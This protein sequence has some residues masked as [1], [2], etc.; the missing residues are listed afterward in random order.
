[1]AHPFDLTDFTMLSGHLATLHGR[2]AE[3]APTVQ[4]VVC[5][6]RDVGAA[7]D[8]VATVLVSER[9]PDGLQSQRFRPGDVVPTDIAAAMFSVEMTHESER[10]G[11]VTFSSDDADAFT[12]EVQRELVLHANL[13]AMAITQELLAVRSAIST[14]HIARGFT[15]LRDFETGTHLERIARYVGLIARA[16]ADDLGV[17]DHYVELVSLYAPLHDIGKVGIPDA[18]LLKPAALDAA[19]WEVMKTHTTKGS[20]L[21]RSISRD[22]AVADPERD[23]MMRNIVE[24]HHETLDG[25]GYPHGLRGDDIPVEARLVAVADIFDALTM[26]RPYR[27]AW[28]VDRAIAKITEL[29]DAGKLDP[30][31]VGVLPELVDEFATIAASSPEPGT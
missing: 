5:T 20:E 30:A 19:E 21:I 2:L 16:A 26:D 14:V 10:F 23:R 8:G 25:T 3:L 1:M 13:M 15:E 31:C 11:D 27:A 17:D 7:V 18:I 29:S 9:A 22:L 4:R 6:F 28:P 12:P 24:L